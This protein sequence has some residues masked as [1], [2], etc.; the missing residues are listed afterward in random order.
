MVGKPARLLV[1][2]A[3]RLLFLAGFGYVSF[4]PAEF[5]IEF[6]FVG[7]AF[8]CRVAFPVASV[9]LLYAC[10]LCVLVLFPIFFVG[11]DQH[12]PV[13]GGRSSLVYLSHVLELLPSEFVGLN[14]TKLLG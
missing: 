12:D 8:S 2:I 14:L 3:A 1:A 9:A 4:S 7:S 11:V 10:A 6:L 13:V 5:A